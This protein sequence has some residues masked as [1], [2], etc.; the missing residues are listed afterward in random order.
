MRIM[1]W[2]PLTCGNV[3]LSVG[4]CNLGCMSRKKK[5][6]RRV[7]RAQVV[8]GP[9]A[10]NVRWDALDGLAG[11]VEDHRL[12]TAARDR[13]VKAARHRGATWVD[14]AGVLGVSRQAAAKRYG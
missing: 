10:G 5:K 11:A 9:G 14:I 8:R 3:A 7:Q 13:A 1:S 12:A 6:R 4:R 2:Q